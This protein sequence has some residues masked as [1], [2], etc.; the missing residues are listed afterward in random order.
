MRQVD[1]GRQEGENADRKGSMEVT[2]EW[3]EVSQRK[4]KNDLSTGYVLWEISP[5]SRITE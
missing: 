1:S 3:Y 5:H 4:T 2:S